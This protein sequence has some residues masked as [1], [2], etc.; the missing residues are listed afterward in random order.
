VGIFSANGTHTLAAGDHPLPE[1]RFPFSFP[2][3]FFSPFLGVSSVARRG[4]SWR[5]SSQY[6]YVL[7]GKLKVSIDGT[8]YMLL[9]GDLLSVEKVRSFPPFSSFLALSPIHWVGADIFDCRARTF[10]GTLAHTRSSCAISFSLLP[11]PV[12][13]PPTLLLLPAQLH[14]KGTS[15]PSCPSLNCHLL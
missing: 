13:T 15:L 7:N 9:P 8:D 14:P 6:K 12:K 1:V 11:F 4:M 3:F 2:L 5:L 10:P